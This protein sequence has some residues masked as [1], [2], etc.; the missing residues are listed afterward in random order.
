M[1]LSPIMNCMLLQNVNSESDK[2]DKVHPQE[3]NPVLDL[4][5][6]SREWEENGIIWRQVASTEPGNQKEL[7]KL[8]EDFES[9]MSYWNIQSKGLS[10]IRKELYGQYF[11]S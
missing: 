5:F 6:P 3:Y 4:I 2:H 10:P 1:S 8:N 9:H 7:L 11:G